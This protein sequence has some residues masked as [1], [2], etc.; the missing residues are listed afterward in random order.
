MSLQQIVAGALSLKPMAPALVFLSFSLLLVVLPRRVSAVLGAPLGLAAAF[1]AAVALL[2]VGRLDARRGGDLE[3][4]AIAHFLPWWLVVL[5]PLLAAGV[6]RSRSMNKG[7]AGGGVLLAY[8][9]LC[10]AAAAATTPLLL[11]SL[12]TAIVGVCAVPVG[13]ASENPLDGNR[14]IRAASRIAVFLSMQTA[15]LLVGMSFLLWS[16]PRLHSKLNV[17]SSAEVFGSAL[18]GVAV[19]SLLGCGPMSSWL[20]G[21]SVGVQGAVNAL[22]LLI[23]SVAMLKMSSLFQH[24]ATVTVLWVWAMGSLVYHLGS[25]IRAR[26]L[27]ATWGNQWGFLASVA[28]AAFVTGQSRENPSMT[29]GAVVLLAF[30]SVSGLSSAALIE[31]CQLSSLGTMGRPQDKQ[32]WVAAL[33]LAGITGLPPTFAIWGFQAVIEGGL[34]AGPLAGQRQSV[35]LGLI[36]GLAV[37][38]WSILKGWVDL[39]KAPKLPPLESEGRWLLLAG[40]FGVLIA[41]LIG[42]F[43][44]KFFAFV[45]MALQAPAAQMPTEPLKP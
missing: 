9:A 45:E 16:S 39:K 2:T 17:A 23:G 1:A 11:L 37:G 38:G 24:A 15:L 8:G 42:L 4:S 7:L 40:M 27:A 5:S 21:G 10:F 3:A 19:F 29:V 34:A 36:V 12:L 20:R 6:H 43:P 41:V 31:S 26:D 25:L 30:L 13:C 14:E 33:T 35:V 18:T 44:A 22:L 32:S 28:A